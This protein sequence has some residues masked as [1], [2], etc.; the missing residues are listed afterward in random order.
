M[1]GRSIAC[2]CIG[3]LERG[4]SLDRTRLVGASVST[5]VH[6]DAVKPEGPFSNV[7]H[8]IDVALIIVMYGG[9]S[10]VGKY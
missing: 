4:P 10:L 2:S 1:R 8:D 9:T 3:R 5:P 6:L 7:T